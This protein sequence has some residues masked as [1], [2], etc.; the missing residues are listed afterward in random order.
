MVV[1]EVAGGVCRTRQVVVV[2]V[3]AS[4]AREPVTA[5]TVA[6]VGDPEEIG[7]RATGRQPDRAG[8]RRSEST[9]LAPSPE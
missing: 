4:H 6:G 2:A 8:L 3:V 5:R 7:D 9:H 1:S